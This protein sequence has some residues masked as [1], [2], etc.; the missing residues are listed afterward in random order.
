MDRV[1][2][3]ITV[4]TDTGEAAVKQLVADALINDGAT[5]ESITSVVENFEY[6]VVGVDGGGERWQESVT[7]ATSIQAEVIAAGR[8]EDRVVADTQQVVEQPPMEPP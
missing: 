1:T 5:L 4:T 7:A 6:K 8:G 2:L 3:H